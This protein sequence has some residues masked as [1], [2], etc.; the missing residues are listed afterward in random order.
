MV[1]SYIR[2]LPEFAAKTNGPRSPEQVPAVGTRHPILAGFEQTD[3]IPFGGRMTNLRVEDNRSVLMTYFPPFPGTPIDDMWTNVP[4]TSVPGLIVGNYGKG[5]VAFLSADLD[6][7]YGMDPI[8]D[9]GNMLR[10]I[11]RW[12]TGEHILVSIEGKAMVGSHC[13]LQQGR[14]IVHLL[15]ETGTDNQ[16]SLL[17]ESYAVGPL[18]VKVK[19][20]AGVKGQAVRL[21]VADATVPHRMTDGLEFDVARLVDHEVVVIE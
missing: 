18:R 5:K 21:L 16:R 19:L 10:N 8:P 11:L 20:P 15:N 17:N 1:N 13:Y 14:L 12:A 6:R 4:R 7:R 2:L 3:I 9:H